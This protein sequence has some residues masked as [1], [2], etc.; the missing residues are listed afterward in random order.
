MRR[1]E[2]MHSQGPLIGDQHALEDGEKPKTEDDDER[3]PYG[4]VE[5]DGKVGPQV[6][7]EQQRGD[8]DVGNDEDRDVLRE[9]VR[10]V[11]VQFLVTN[12]ASIVGLEIA[13][14]DLAFAAGGT[15]VA[16]PALHRELRI[17][18]RQGCARG[19]LIRIGK[20]GCWVHGAF[21]RR[22]VVFGLGHTLAF[23]TRAGRRP[24][25]TRVPRL[26]RPSPRTALV[27]VDDLEA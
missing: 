26:I 21:A 5:R 8:A 6:V 2:T 17:A 9:I 16:Q 25:V 7:D 23:A 12:R 22:Y 24:D 14:E 27:A 1:L 11:M 15:T 18:L 19:F 4:I 10:A 13:A 3:R 20:K